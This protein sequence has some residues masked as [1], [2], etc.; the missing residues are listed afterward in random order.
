[1][2][3]HELLQQI[4]EFVQKGLLSKEELLQAYQTGRGGE[5]V[6]SKQV[7]IAQV[8]YYIGAAI[9]F[10]G[11][12]I[13]VF[14][15]WDALSK[16]TQILVTL[17]SSIAA[18]VVGV[19]FREYQKFKGV[20]LAFFL[21]SALLAP[22]GLGVTF[23][24]AGYEVGDSS[25]QTLIAGIS[26]AVYLAS[27]WLYKK[28]IFLI[29]SVVF[30]T[31]LFFAVTSML[32][33]GRPEIYEMKFVEYRVLAVGLTYLLLGYSF[34]QKGMR[35]LSGWM[36]SAGLI[37]FLGAAMFLGG[38]TPEQNRF[39]EAIFP[40]L[41]FGAIILSI[42]LRSRA[43]L[44]FGTLFLMGYILKI[45]AE[46]FTDTLGW[47]LALVIAGFALIGVGYGTYSLNQKYLAKPLKSVS[48][49]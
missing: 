34:A 13:L 49:E 42:Y 15:N 39:W 11:I 45:T 14:Q 44:I 2:E 8:L 41:A 43:F 31:W 3:K 47:P 20:S 35:D 24:A 29:F 22:V 48:L 16:A 36:Y 40:G 33:G 1:M 21:I 30:G 12:V 46:Y 9:V 32:V 7:N 25:I 6:D 26:L 5:Y 19:L 23:D 27:Y 18:Y 17:G 37:A 10:L 4:T 28:T 38:W